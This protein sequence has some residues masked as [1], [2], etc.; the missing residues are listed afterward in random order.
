V[1]GVLGVVAAMVLAAPM[2][3][4]AGAEPPDDST[5]CAEPS[6]PVEIDSVADAEA[7]LVGTWVRCPGTPRLFWAHEGDDVGFEFTA[8]GRFFRIYDAPDGALIRPGGLLQEGI[9][10]LD[11]VYDGS[12]VNLNL[13]L[14]G[15][16]MTPLNVTFHD[17]ERSMRFTDVMAGA[18]AHYV[19]AP[20][21]AH[22]PGLPAGVGEGAC[23]HP[24]GPIVVE[25]SAQLEELLIGRWTLCQDEDA[26]LGADPFG[27]G[28]VGVEFAGD[29]TFFQL[30]HAADG[31]VV[32][33]AP[34]A[35][36]T[37]LVYPFDEPFDIHNAPQVDIA[38]P[39]G[40]TRIMS[41][42]FLSSPLFI[43]LGPGVGLVAGDPAPI[44]VPPADMPATGAAVPW[45]VVLIAAAGL[46]AGSLAALAARVTRPDG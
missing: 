45:A 17:E 30:V 15:S 33:D 6:E 25:S 27:P 38:M 29:G 41:P 23:G 9:W 22:G 35:G 1:L 3:A 40:G 11:A 18:T 13:K 10:D 5:P 43:V 26:V 36:A 28:V 34:S 46:V 21:A 14:L 42:Q 16:G 8:D 7:L 37:W 2:P 39:G 31:S 20:D 4:T 12:S 32:P 24:T 19:R 44:P